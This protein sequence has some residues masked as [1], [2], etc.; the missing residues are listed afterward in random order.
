[1]I[2]VLFLEGD[3]YDLDSDIDSDV[4][5]DIVDLVDLRWISRFE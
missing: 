1:M 5:S 4:D 3:I 2:N